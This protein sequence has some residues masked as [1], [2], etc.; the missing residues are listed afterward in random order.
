LLKKRLGP[1][2]VSTRPAFGGQKVAYLEGF[3]V[4]NLANEIFGF[5]NWST[6]VTSLTT[7]F[8]DYKDGRYFVGVTALVKVIIKDG[9]FHEDVG[10][11][12][13]DNM[14]SKSASLEKAKKQAVTDGIKRALKSYGNV[15]GN[16]LNDKSYVQFLA[17]QTKMPEQYDPRDILNRPSDIHL[18]KNSMARNP[19]SPHQ[20]VGAE[21]FLDVLTPNSASNESAQTK[22]ERLKKAQQKKQE[23]EVMK[24]KCPD[25]SSLSTCSAPSESKLAKFQTSA[26]NT[27]ELLIEDDDD[28]WQNMTQMQNSMAEEAISMTPGK[29]SSKRVGRTTPKRGQLNR[30]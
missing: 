28:F 23:F 14:R 8:I 22:S 30:L 15:F 11:G 5:N 17:K 1:N 3:R 6:S 10:Y 25:T 24:R 21:N 26:K 27:P 18:S 2:Y 29:K 7:D 4:Q 9:A 20:L 12:T 13:S 16:C 19:I